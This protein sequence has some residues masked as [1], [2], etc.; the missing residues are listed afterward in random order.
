MLAEG[1]LLIVLLKARN[2]INKDMKTTEKPRKGF[3]LIELLVVIAIIGILASMLLPAL[4]KARKKGNRAKCLNNLG[5]IAKAWNGFAS[6]EQNGEYPWMMTQRSLNAVYDDMPR[7]TDGTTW[8]KGRWWHCRNIELM[9]SAVGSDL[10]T[11]K[12][13]MSPCD[14][15]VKN[16]NQY[17]VGR[18]NCTGRRRDHGTF[19]GWNAAENHAQSYAVHLGASQQNSNSIIASTKNWVGADMGGPGGRRQAQV[20][21]TE[22]YDKNGDGAFDPCSRAANWGVM[23]RQGESI[24]W[25][26]DAG[27]DNLVLY[28]S[29]PRSVD[30]DGWNRYLC[31]GHA[32]TL[33]HDKDGDGVFDVGDG[34]IMANGFIG[35]GV[36]GQVTYQR[37][38]RRNRVLS[39]LVMT[40][41]EYNQGQVALSGG[42]AMQANDSEF[43]DRVTEHAKDLGSHIHVLEVVSQPTR[44]MTP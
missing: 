42:S 5:Q 10:G 2:L 11:I 37:D 8:G 22:P 26:G 19:G 30:A 12:T 33:R 34:D 18:E 21:P 41:L 6:E 24:F 20:I 38:S 39:S 14:P 35:A 31:Q 7:G 40:G 3:T 32:D 23:N 44:D 25:R 1:K 17:A 15:G 43:K 36:D 27:N 16:S 29:I 13:L 4:A 28:T 9:W